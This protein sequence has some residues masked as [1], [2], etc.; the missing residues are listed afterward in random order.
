M[1]PPLSTCVLTRT[2]IRTSAPLCSAAAFGYRASRLCDP[3]L[4]LC[5]L[6]VLVDTSRTMVGG[7]GSGQLLLRVAAHTRVSGDEYTSAPVRQVRVP[8]VATVKRA[9][10]QALQSTGSGGAGAVAVTVGAAI[11]VGTGDLKAKLVLAPGMEP[12]SIID[13]LP[14]DLQLDAA[15][16]SQKVDIHRL[17]RPPL[18]NVYVD[19][20]TDAPTRK[21]ARTSPQRAPA[22]HAV[23]NV[24]SVN[25]IGTHA[26]PAPPLATFAA[27]AAARGRGARNPVAR[28]RRRSHVQAAAAIAA[29]AERSQ[30][31][32]RK[33]AS[34]SASAADAGGSEHVVQ[35]SS[36]GGAGGKG[37]GGGANGRMVVESV[38][39]E[40]L[41]APDPCAD[42]YIVMSLIAPCRLSSRE[43]TLF[44][45]L[46]G[47]LATEQC[48]MVLPAA[49]EPLRQMLS[50]A[51]IVL[52]AFSLRTKRIPKPLFDL[53]ANNG[54]FD[55]NQPDLS[56]AQPKSL[57]RFSAAAKRLVEHP[58]LVTS[59]QDK[60]NKMITSNQM[61]SQNHSNHQPPITTH[62]GHHWN[63]SQTR[64]H[65]ISLIQIIPEFIPTTQSINHPNNAAADAAVAN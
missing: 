39:F 17:P 56:Q 60:E 40:A 6:G 26:A 3:H 30:R 8:G 45:A 63:R 38:V 14:L 10:Q 20:V 51:A 48:A 13:G 59:S 64:N 49:E 50:D 32:R 57:S 42:T 16:S 19:A 35:S 33:R 5:V 23:N 62:P 44:C 41:S 27:R 2:R 61:S 47:A 53:I 43:N 15:A 31:T 36:G 54:A 34:V 12:V 4:A 46:C 65:L 11:S 1:V 52:A 28:S 22:P 25:G 55:S 58:F 29:D 21:R 24:N 37:N 7:G 18:L 9:V